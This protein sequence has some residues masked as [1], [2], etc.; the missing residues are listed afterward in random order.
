MTDDRHADALGVTR[1]ERR[2][3]YQGTGGRDI[4]IHD[5]RPKDSR[6]D[7]GAG[8]RGDSIDADG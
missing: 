6:S 5:S 1:R 8:A 4:S 3:E 2:Q 7:A